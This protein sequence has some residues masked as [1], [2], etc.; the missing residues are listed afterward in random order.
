MN[1]EG[2]CQCD[3]GE[4]GAQRERMICELGCPYWEYSCKGLCQCL[5][6]Q[7]ACPAETLHEPPPLPAYAGAVAR[8]HRLGAKP[9]AAA[10]APEPTAA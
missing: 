8:P 4:C 6:Q 9:P 2:T 5:V 1:Y 7:G 10:S 3:I